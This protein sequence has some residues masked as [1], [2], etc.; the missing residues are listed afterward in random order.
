VK[1]IIVGLDGS[2][3]DEHLVDWAG[4]LANEQGAHI[5]AAHFVPRATLWMIAGAQVDSAP[6]LSEL[7]DHFEA[8]VVSRLRGHVPSVHLHVALGDP[9]HS[10]A[11]LAHSSDAQLIAISAPVHSALHDAVFGSVAYRLIHL[12]R[13][14]VVAVP[15]P[16]RS[17]TLVHGAS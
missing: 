5:I 15:R 16:A 6:Y 10:L 2:D 14:P 7:H 12:T 11:A 4:D 8:G 3:T 13:V 1:R 17:F 9:A